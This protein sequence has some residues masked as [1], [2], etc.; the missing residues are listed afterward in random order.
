MMQQVEELLQKPAIR[1]YFLRLVGEEGLQL[2]L[3]FPD[4]G[5]H[6]DEELAESTGINLNSV[7]HSLYTL[8]ERRL[9]VY[10][11]VKDNETGWLTYLWHLQLDELEAVL[12]EELDRVKEKLVVRERYEEEN[13][14]YLCKTCGA[15]FTFN[16]AYKHDFSCTNCDVPLAHFDNEMLALALRRRLEAITETLG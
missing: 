6:S 8:Y 14:F 3:R 15:M 13:D 10:R 5:E 7:R 1:S 9:A 4:E 11:R 16:D 12:A 2:L